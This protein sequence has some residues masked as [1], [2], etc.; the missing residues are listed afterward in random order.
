MKRKILIAGILALFSSC[1]IISGIAGVAGSVEP[2]IGAT[3]IITRIIGSKNGE[4]K[5]KDVK[6]RFSDAELVMDNGVAII[7]GKLSHNGPVKKNLVLRVPCQDKDGHE[8]GMATDRIEQMEKYQK[9]EF[10]AKLYNPDVRTCKMTEAK[11][12]EENIDEILLEME[13]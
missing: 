3:N 11:I 4:I 12:I 5:A 13:K 9:W 7:T 10:K 8:I 2:I 6:Y 1:S